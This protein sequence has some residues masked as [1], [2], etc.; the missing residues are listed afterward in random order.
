MADFAFPRFTSG[1]SERSSS[2]L[3]DEGYQDMEVLAMDHVS[4]S[5]EQM[6]F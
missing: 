6:I 4:F 2:T 5:C 1:A 3:P